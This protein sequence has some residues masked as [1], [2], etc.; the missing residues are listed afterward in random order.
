MKCILLAHMAYEILVSRNGLMIREDPHHVLIGNRPKASK[1][2]LDQT[3][4]CTRLRR[5]MPWAASPL[6]LA[7]TNGRRASPSRSSMR[8]ANLES[9]KTLADNVALIAKLEDAIIKQC[10][11]RP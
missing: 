1:T 3:W 5:A 9:T 7:W 10:E 8:D 2:S 11:K 6:L 4:R